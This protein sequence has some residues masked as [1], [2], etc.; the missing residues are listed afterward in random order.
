MN[1]AVEVVIL[2][3]FRAG[4]FGGKRDFGKQKVALLDVNLDSFSKAGEKRCPCLSA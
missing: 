2:F 1:A 3:A 4:G